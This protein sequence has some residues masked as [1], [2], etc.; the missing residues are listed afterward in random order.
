MSDEP[1]EIEDAAFIGK[2]L[3]RICY[4]LTQLAQ[5]ELLTHKQRL[6]MMAAIKYVA[7]VQRD[8]ADKVAEGLYE[9]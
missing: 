2:D 9:K 3:A 6:E 5:Q 8:M 4:E 7:S 1:E